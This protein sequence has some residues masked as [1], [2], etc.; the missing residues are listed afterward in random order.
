MYLAALIL[1]I[2]TSVLGVCMVSSQLREADI[3][4][5]FSQL[6]LWERLWRMY[7]PMHSILSISFLH[8]LLDWYTERS[9]HHCMGT[10]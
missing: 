9:L 2:L 1:L 3:S 7:T 6:T 10:T 8:H 5:L 4:I